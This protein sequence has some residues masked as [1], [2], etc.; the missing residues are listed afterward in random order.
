MIRIIYIL[1]KLGLKRRG[2][3]MRSAFTY[4]TLTSAAAVFLLELFER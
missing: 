2:T 1:Y 4:L 3:R